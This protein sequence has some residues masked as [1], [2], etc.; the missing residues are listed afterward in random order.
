MDG[1][2][3][4]DAE[5]R[6]SRT[7]RTVC[8]TFYKQHKTHPQL[9]CREQCLIWGAQTLRARGTWAFSKQNCNYSNGH[10]RST[11]ESSAWDW[12]VKDKVQ[13]YFS[14]VRR[15]KLLYKY[16]VHNTIHIRHSTYPNYTHIV[17]NVE[18]PIVIISQ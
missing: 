1:T 17:T 3:R 4:T 13:K 2:T 10:Y 5:V 9:Q 8:N 15:R 7:G 14:R 16:T 12:V 6:I 11:T 18:C